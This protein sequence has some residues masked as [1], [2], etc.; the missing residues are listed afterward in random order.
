MK[1]G[2]LWP[3][4]TKLSLKVCQTDRFHGNGGKPLI[5]LFAPYNNNFQFGLFGPYWGL[6]STSVI[7]KKLTTGTKI[8]INF[9]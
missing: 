7:F 9:F 4:N 5:F 2:N 6:A 1:S 3:F 8:S